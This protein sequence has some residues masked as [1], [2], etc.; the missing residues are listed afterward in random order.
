MKTI[1]LKIIRFLKFLLIYFQIGR[2]HSQPAYEIVRNDLR[3][4]LPSLRSL[5]EWAS[6]IDMRHGV[7]EDILCVL[8]MAGKQMDSRDRVVVLGYDEMSVSETVER[9][10][11]ND[12][13]IGP[14]R[15][16][17]VISAR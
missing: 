15:E 1:I 5:R 11:R 16:M 9:D 6:N 12:E 8:E 10:K 17:Q 2:Y 7:L 14:H 3:I 4:P 13:I